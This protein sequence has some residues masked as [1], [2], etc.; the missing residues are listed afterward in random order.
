[1]YKEQQQENAD[2]GLEESQNWK[3]KNI[4]FFFFFKNGCFTTDWTF[5]FSKPAPFLLFQEPDMLWIP[6]HLW[7]QATV[8]KVAVGSRRPD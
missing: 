1:M 2:E 4:F 8:E 7:T 5:D 6:D 3:D